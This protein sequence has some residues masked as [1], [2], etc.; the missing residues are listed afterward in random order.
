M[1]F[2]PYSAVAPEK[3]D[4]SNIPV[5]SRPFASDGLESRVAFLTGA[6]LFITMSRTA[7]QHTQP[8]SQVCT[9][10]VKAL[11]GVAKTMCAQIKKG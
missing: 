8:P 9:P 2:G 1:A 6:L 10:E 11:E 3:S 5:Y 4:N 7:L